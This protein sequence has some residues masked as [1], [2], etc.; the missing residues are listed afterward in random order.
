VSRSRAAASVV[1]SPVLLGAITLLV[2][3]VAVFLAYNANRGLPFIPTYN[4]RAQVP[5]AAS[6]VEGNEVRV[7]GFRVGTVE[8]LRPDT[9]PNGQV[10]A[11]FDLKLNKTIEP[12]P[13]DTQI[14][15]RPRSVLGLKYVDLKPGTSPR[16]LKPGSTLPVTNAETVV[17]IDDVLNTFDEETRRDAQTSLQG[18]G[19]AL[20]GRGQSLNI[21]LQELPR[22]FVHLKP[23]MRTLSDPQTGLRNF[24]KQLAD[25]A[26]Q[27]APVARTQA[28]LFTNM[29]DTFEAF[30]ANPPAL[31][32]TISR[33][34]PL[35]RTGLDKFP[36]QRVFLAN[37]EDLMGKLRPS[38]HELRASLPTINTALVEGTR[39]N[40]ILPIYT[41]EL[42]T[43]L[44]AIDHLG[45]DPNTLL[46]LKDLTV[47]TNVLEPL[48]E[49]VAPYQTVCNDYVYWFNSLG[50]HISEPVDDPATG[51]RV[52]GTGQRVLA[53]FENTL[54]QDNRLSDNHA[55]RP[56]DVSREK[57]PHTARDP[58][59]PPPG[60]QHLHKLNGQPHSPAIDAGGNAD[61]QV[62]QFGNP[63]GPLITGGR[64]P[65]R[66]FNELA[67]NSPSGGSHVLGDS[68]TPGL[69]GPTFTGVPDL[70]DV[71][72]DL[73]K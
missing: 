61:C 18:F 52:D 11:L 15:V 62:G 5:S 19:D 34:P 8:N 39:T 14:V 40:R 35:Y 45:S 20:A 56:A 22:L 13:I 46:A 6:L 26:T 16:V 23:V 24:F 10:N 68:N 33:Q 7:A 58:L 50:E 60:G 41:R 66:H 21:T 49:Y 4:L 63:H 43:L 28:I 71:D 67:P 31:R 64:Y 36:F 48:L 29:A 25:T 47:T 3:L 9:G 38:A 32:E 73:R 69:A 37:T 55:D 70:R 17:D 57:D 72:K 30:S 53:K 51:P 59:S 2:V 1:G 12:L 27:V 42:R 44:K 65:P 54:L